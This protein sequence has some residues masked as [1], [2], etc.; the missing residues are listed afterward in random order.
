MYNCT[1]GRRQPHFSF[2]LLIAGLGVQLSGPQREQLH[3]CAQATACFSLQRA[4]AVCVGCCYAKQLAPHKVAGHV[5]VL[6]FATSA[7]AIEQRQ[8]LFAHTLDPIACCCCCCCCHC[9]PCSYDRGLLLAQGLSAGM[10]T[11]CGQALTSP[12]L[13]AAAAAVSVQPAIFYDRPFTSF[14]PQRRHG[15][16]VWPSVWRGSLHAFGRHLAASA[17]GVLDCVHPSGA[18]VAELTR[19]AAAAGATTRWEVPRSCCALVVVLQMT[20]CTCILDVLL[21]S[22]AAVAAFARAAAAAG[23]RWCCST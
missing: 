19:A 15:D 7:A 13:A 2:S 9:W 22:G 23:A 11:L 8:L 1:G 12:H 21:S 6:A 10:E 14:G 3:G 18:A 4:S 17:A 20:V 5:A 16:A